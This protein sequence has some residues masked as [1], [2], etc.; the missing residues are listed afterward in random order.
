MQAQGVGNAG[1]A[2]EHLL[3]GK[4]RLGR[5][6]QTAAAEPTRLLA[7]TVKISSKNE[8]G[9]SRQD[10]AGNRPLMLSWKYQLTM[11]AVKGRKPV[12]D[13]EVTISLKDRTLKKDKKE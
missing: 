9:E 11:A 8:T 6:Q 7:A 4:H 3:Y 1:N 5:Q 12:Q 13:I 10:E 2:K